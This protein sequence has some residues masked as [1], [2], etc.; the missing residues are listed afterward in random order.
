MGKD[1]KSKISLFFLLSYIVLIPLI[2]GFMK[3][4]EN[5]IITNVN[6]IKINDMNLFTYRVKNGTLFIKW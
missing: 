3:I 6:T 5:I 2:N 4:L 1:K